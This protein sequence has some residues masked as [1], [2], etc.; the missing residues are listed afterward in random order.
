MRILKTRI[1]LV[2]SVPFTYPLRFVEKVFTSSSFYVD[3]NCTYPTVE[4]QVGM[5]RKIA[6]SLSSDTN[7]QSKGA[8]MFFRR[9]KRSHKWVH[10][11]TSCDRLFRGSSE[12]SM[13]HFESEFVITLGM[14]FGR[15]SS[16]PR[17]FHHVILGITRMMCECSL[18]ALSR[19]YYSIPFHQ[20]CVREFR[21]IA[22]QS[23]M[24]SVS[25]LR[26]LPSGFS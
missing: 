8:N 1:L 10:Q 9:V 23:K 6:E 19:S 22:M 15:Y 4:E 25:Y 12:F 26:N 21:I 11:G 5:A 3:E 20:N 14:C 24:I 16:F 13:P 7:K 2:R 18:L 17:I